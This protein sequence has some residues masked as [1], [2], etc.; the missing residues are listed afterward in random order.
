MIH[1]KIKKQ[2]I[3]KYV[4]SHTLVKQDYVQ[5]CKIERLKLNVNICLVSIS[6]TIT[7]FPKKT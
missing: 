6:Y 5:N 7:V 4:F 3:F 1:K 2:V